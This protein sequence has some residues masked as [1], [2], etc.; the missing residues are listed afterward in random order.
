MSAADASGDK[1]GP[2]PSPEVVSSDRTRVTRTTSGV[3]TRWEAPTAEM[4]ADAFPGLKV[5]A[6]C[7]VGGMGA[8]YRAEQARLGRT[9][10]VKILSTGSAPDDEAIERFE[11]EA[12]IL[13]GLNHPH[14]LSLH[15]FG[16]LP[17][18]TLYLVM[19]WAG[20]GDLSKLLAGRA[21]PPG[22][23]RI[24]VDQI[25]AALGAAHAR[26]VIHRDL[27]PANVLVLEDGRLTLA[28]FGLA[29]AAGGFTAA[30]TAK[31]A[32]FGT[33]EYMAPEQMESAGRVTPAADLYA[34][35]VMTYQMLTGRV[36]RGA[37][38]RPSR[39]ARVPPEVDAFLDAAMA[40]DVNRRPRDAGE[41]AR[42]FERACGA[43]RRR[44]RR[45]LIGLGI[46]LII[47]TLAWARAEI[48]RAEREAAWAEARA[49]TISDALRAATRR[50]ES[51]AS[52][53][54]SAPVVD[55][56]PPAADL[57]SGAEISPE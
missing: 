12:R 32:I 52:A 9:V 13:S 36:P 8:V 55:A 42:L 51:A 27:K 50:R 53:A 33:F 43:P 40:T 21:H 3:V 54:R 7:G 14:I 22:L 15:D 46:T 45:Q 37:Y 28:D 35:G 18:G 17:D 31:G 48:I 44:L 10:A 57:R 19:E 49:A 34:L 20:G 1:K 26:G 47:F 25:A 2:A 24:W 16:A 41:F 4:L 23:V 29:H 38:A 6:L 5:R 30:L 56:P 11:R 39:L